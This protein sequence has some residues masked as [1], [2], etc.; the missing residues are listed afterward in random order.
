M[1]ERF[2]IMT[3]RQAARFVEDPSPESIRVRP[4]VTVSLVDQ[5]G[6]WFVGTG[7]FPSVD[8]VRWLGMSDRTLARRRKAGLLDLTEAERLLR[9]VRLKLQANSV[10]GRT[11]GHATRWMVTANRALGGMSPMTAIAT[12]QGAALVSSLLLQLQEGVMV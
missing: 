6:E 2:A 7:C 10:L 5:V 4:R 11:G 9:L 8:L 12:E 3:V 1:S